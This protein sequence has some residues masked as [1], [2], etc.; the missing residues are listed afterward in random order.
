MKF[1]Q[2][3]FGW[4]MATLLV[5]AVIFLVMLKVENGRL[6][7]YQQSDIDKQKAYNDSIIDLKNLEIDS[8]IL[9]NDLKDD[10]IEIATENFDSL[11][12][13]KDSVRVIYKDRYKEVKDFDA[14]SIVKYWGDEFD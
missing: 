13:S 7:D 10:V 14:N 11:V 3:I 6:K 8:L 5:V 12:T 2:N 4:V 1:R 9:V